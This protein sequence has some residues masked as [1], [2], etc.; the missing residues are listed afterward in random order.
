[1]VKSKQTQ[2]LEERYGKSQSKTNVIDLGEWDLNTIIKF[3]DGKERQLVHIEFRN[4]AIDL[5]RFDDGTEIFTGDIKDSFDLTTKFQ[6][7]HGKTLNIGDKVKTKW[8][9]GG[10]VILKNNEP[11]FSFESGNFVIPISEEAIK[12]RGIVKE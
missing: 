10:Y 9:G 11:C 6:D 2:E 3:K 12:F 4:M 7:I 1:M 8:G 5:L